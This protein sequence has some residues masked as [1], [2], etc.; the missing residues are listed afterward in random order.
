[1]EGSRLPWTRSKV[2]SL[3]YWNEVW[4]DGL[5]KCKRIMRRDERRWLKM[6]LDKEAS[7]DY[8]EGKVQFS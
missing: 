4:G 2:G 1:M 6:E 8:D 7:N 3:L 5:R